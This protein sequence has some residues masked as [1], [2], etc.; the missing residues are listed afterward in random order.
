M[1]LISLD[2]NGGTLFYLN[3]Q[4]HVNTILRHRGEEDFPSCAN[5]R[6][7]A[8]SVARVGPLRASSEAAAL[9]LSSFSAGCAFACLAFAEHSL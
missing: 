5:M 8:Y 1:S 4:N 7:S 6:V 3:R 9:F 2:S